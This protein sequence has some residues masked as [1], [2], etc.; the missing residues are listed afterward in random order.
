M[1]FAGLPRWVGIARHRCIRQAALHWAMSSFCHA[2]LGCHN[3]HYICSLR[4]SGLVPTLSLCAPFLP[5]FISPVACRVMGIYPAGV[6]GRAFSSARFTRPTSFHAEG[7]L[8]GFWS[9]D[10]GYARLS[11]LSG[12]PLWDPVG[13]RAPGAGSS[14]AL[15]GY[16]LSRLA[17][18]SLGVATILGQPARGANSSNC[19]QSLLLAGIGSCDIMIHRSQDASTELVLLIHVRSPRALRF[20]LRPSGLGGQ[21][22]HDLLY[23]YL[24]GSQDR[25]CQHSIRATRGSSPVDSA[26]SGADLLFRLFSSGALSV[27]FSCAIITPKCSSLCISP[28]RLELCVRQRSIGDWLYGRRCY[29]ASLMMSVAPG[30]SCRD[31]SYHSIR[32]FNTLRQDT[33]AEPSLACWTSCTSF[34]IV[35]VSVALLSAGRHSIP[36]WPAVCYL[37]SGGCVVTSFLCPDISAAPS[38][39]PDHIQHTWRSPFESFRRGGCAM[40]RGG[41][42]GRRPHKSPASIARSKQRPGKRERRAQRDAGTEASTTVGYTAASGADATSAAAPPATL[43]EAS[44]N[45]EGASISGP[46]R[47]LRKLR[48]SPCR[49]LLPRDWIRHRRRHRRA[50]PSHC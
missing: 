21:C 48:Q 43:A 26:E 46:A 50:P 42:R 34:W 27:W 1:H 23:V 37:G 41:H 22:K 25:S 45:A 10:Y 11:S 13:N 8:S 2:C 12:T 36:P 29:R 47:R 20:R 15:T 17:Q 39:V 38:L 28:V 14:Y 24:S 44:V 4:Q 5:W 30:P 9:D 3:F 33:I 32:F 6:G 35:H 19:L 16:C 31:L 49:L 7:A 40:G 18:V